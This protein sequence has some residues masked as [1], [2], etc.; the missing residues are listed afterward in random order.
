MGKTGGRFPPCQLLGWK[1]TRNVAPASV[2]AHN[3]ELSYSPGTAW[4]G[5]FVYRVSVQLMGRAEELSDLMSLLPVF[6]VE[7]LFPLASSVIS[8]TLCPVICYRSYKGTWVFC[9]LSDPLITFSW[10]PSLPSLSFIVDIFCSFCSLIPTI[11]GQQCFAY[12]VE[13]EFPAFLIIFRCL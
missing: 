11:W 12:S 3:T 7:L 10:S 6:A 13:Q 5:T 4:S 8:K 2:H 9:C 1:A